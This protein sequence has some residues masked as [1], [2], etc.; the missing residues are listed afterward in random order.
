MIYDITFGS[1]ISVSS[2]NY[3]SE[4]GGGA[5]S[6]LAAAQILQ[7]YDDEQGSGWIG[8]V[9]EPGTALLVGLGTILL[10]ATR[11]HS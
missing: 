2:F 4:E 10:G 3:F 7:I 8:A 6:Y 5:G 11:R 1:A 9:P